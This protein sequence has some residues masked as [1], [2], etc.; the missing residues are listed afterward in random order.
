M[1]L[2]RESRY[3]LAALVV[4][5]GHPP[6]EVV[7]SGQ[8]AREAGLPAPFLSKIMRS[9]ARG[10]VLTSFRGRGYVL[11]KP[12]S[13]MTLRDILHAVEGPG[14]FE[15]R[16]IFW[17]EECSSD[18][19]CVLHWRWSELKPQIE[20]TMGGITLAEIREN[21]SDLVPLEFGT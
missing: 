14:L 1:R 21:G 18:N 13:Q 4:I 2:S 6:G 16:C 8:I 19:P 10:D 17:R 15:D 11:A 7:E 20:Q 5:A 3:A 12:A 9:L